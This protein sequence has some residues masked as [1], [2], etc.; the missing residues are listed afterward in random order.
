M[1]SLHETM[2]NKPRNEYKLWFLD[3]TRE[4]NTFDEKLLSLTKPLP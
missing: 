1:S 3:A 2:Q 4:Q